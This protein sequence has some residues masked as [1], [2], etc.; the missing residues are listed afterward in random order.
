MAKTDDNLKGKVASG[1][2]WK[3]GER[4]IA[5]GI[6]FIISTIL[7]RILMPEMYGTISLVLIFINLANVF[8]TNGLGEALIRK[9]DADDTDFSTVFYCSLLVSI[10]LYG[11]LFVSAQWIADFYDNAELV[12]VLRVLS[13]QIPLSSVKTIQNAYVSKHLL[14]KK[15]FFS[16]LGGTIVSGIIGI[17]MAL[18]GAGVWALVEQYLVNSI[19]DMTVLFFTVPWR[20]KRIFDKNAARF[21]FSY[22]WK[23]VAASFINQLY[24]EIRS[25][26]IGKKYT[27]SDLAYYQKGDHFPSLVI[28]NINSSI[29]TVLFPAMAT[30]NDDI[31]RL[32]N[33]TRRSMK[34]TS[35]IIFPMLAGLIA[36]ADPLIRLLLTEKW[37][38]CIP[39]LRLGCLYWLFQPMQTANYQ[40]I[41]AV[42]RSDICLKLEFVKK[43]IGIALIIITMQISVFALALSNVFVACLSMILNMAPNKKLIGYGFGEQFRDIAPATILSAIMGTL[44]WSVSLLQMP[45]MVTLIIQLIMGGCLYLGGS[46]IFKIDSFTYLLDFIKTRRQKR[47]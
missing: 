7:A 30:V 39:F 3:F 40:A 14:F 1:L 44:V 42:G 11:V 12:L 13:L 15:F 26:I 29:S 8:I 47:A 41:K 17:I 2:A 34:L 45:D 35:Y 46:K 33:M 43:G 19:V 25:I 16:T 18:N 27:T 5:Q 22:G 9:K 23:L 38:L 37:M 24:S 32:K 20:P 28:T 36:V 6:S 31:E 10:I 4:I 21:A